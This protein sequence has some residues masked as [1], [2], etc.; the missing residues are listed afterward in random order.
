MFAPVQILTSFKGCAAATVEQPSRRT[1]QA[2]Y[3]DPK[4]AGF[5]D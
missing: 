4:A 5:A 2:S 1:R 3:P